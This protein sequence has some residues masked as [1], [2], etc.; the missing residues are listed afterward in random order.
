MLLGIILAVISGV[1]VIALA[2]KKALDACTLVVT[3]WKNLI[4]A[5]KKSRP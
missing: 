1:T 4:K 3:A 5:I 2:L